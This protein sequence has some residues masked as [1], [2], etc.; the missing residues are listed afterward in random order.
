[1]LGGDFVDIYNIGEDHLGVYIADVSG[2][3]VSASV[4][5][6]ARPQDAAPSPVRVHEELAPAAPDAP[7]SAA[8]APQAPKASSQP[9]EHAASERASSAE[10]VAVKTVPAQIDAGQ[11]GPADSSPQALAPSRPAPPKVA[12][13]PTPAAKQA[14]GGAKNI[15]SAV[16]YVT[17]EGVN[18]RL[19]G[20]APLACKPMLLRNPDR[21]ALDFEGQWN[22]NVPAVPQ[23]K[24]IKSIRVGR[25]ADSTRLVVDLHQAPASYRLIK[26]SPQGLD[27]RLR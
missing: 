23:N 15:T 7:G 11:T 10:G 22:V 27:V 17:K 19:G 16:V 3:G 1:M 12:A 13:M 18:L 20:D 5:D 24:L 21:L 14:S 4:T 8:L 2:H 6:K 9:V 26:T 25:Q